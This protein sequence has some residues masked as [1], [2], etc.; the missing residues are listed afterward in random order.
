MDIMALLYALAA[1]L[2]IYVAL[3]VYHAPIA[4][5]GV[6]CGLIIEGMQ[7]GYGPILYRRQ[8]DGWELAIK[9]VPFGGYTEFKMDETPQEEDQP[10]GS[11]RLEGLSGLTAAGITVSGPVVTA[12]LGLA[13]AG[14]PVWAGADQLVVTAPAD[15]M[16]HPCAVPGLALRGE[17]STWDGQYTLFRETAVEFTLRL[18]TFQSLSEWGGLFGFIVTCGGVGALSA[19][20][21]LSSVGVVLVWIG[22][23]NL[24]PVPPLN[25]YHAL[26]GVY[27]AITGKPLSKRWRMALIWIGVLVMLVLTVR[28]MW[29]D[30]RWLLGT[31]FG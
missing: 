28:T 27:K 2:M 25:G 11:G 13:V 5:L 18:V 21:W 29:I 22:L 8:F 24:L 3:G 16:V 10:E 17:P 23:V 26:C 7:F 6:R 14:L 12:L 1:Y 30:V 4:Y 9:L 19:W 31:I 20:A 15:S